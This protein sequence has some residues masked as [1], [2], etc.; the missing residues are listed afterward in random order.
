[1]PKYYI[2][3]SGTMGLIDG[4]WRLFS[5]VGDYIEIFREHENEKRED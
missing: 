1:M 5:D 3:P 4:E 2:V